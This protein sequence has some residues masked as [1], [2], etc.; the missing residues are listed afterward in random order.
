M[1]DEQI[2]AEDGGRVIYTTTICYVDGNITKL[3][4]DSKEARNKEFKDMVE[5]IKNN[6]RAMLIMGFTLAMINNITHIIIDE[7]EVEEVD[8][9]EVDVFG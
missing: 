6:D 7:E 2:Q 1:E 8:E 9:D 4:Y 3:S 5:S